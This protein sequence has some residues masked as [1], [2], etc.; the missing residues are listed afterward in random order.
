MSKPET[1]LIAA[2]VETI[3]TRMPMLAWA[4]R[5]NSSGYRGRMQGC[6]AGTPDVEILLRGGRVLH[7]EA[8]GTKDTDVSAAQ[9][10]WHARAAR[11]QHTVIV[12]R[13]VQSVIDAVQSAMR[14]EF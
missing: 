13:D 8:K 4:R 11:L 1:A 12:A 7:V 9:L 2:I 6:E 14:A 5:L 3:N 10:K